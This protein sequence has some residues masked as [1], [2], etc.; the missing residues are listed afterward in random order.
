[1]TTV[2]IG[3]RFGRLVVLG[4]VPTSGVN[5]HRRI[6]A[7]CD[8]GAT[9]EARWAH[10]RTGRTSSCG[11]FNAE[12][13]AERNRTHGL[14]GT[15]IWLRWRNMLQRCTNSH[16]PDYRHYG[17]RG[18]TVCARWRSF[19]AFYADMGGSSTLEIT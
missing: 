14:A 3:T 13:S 1:M 8:C 11:C 15:Q 19:E 5:R 7:R 17:G 4:V 2:A 9:V 6:S 18:I 10:V 16:R 12:V